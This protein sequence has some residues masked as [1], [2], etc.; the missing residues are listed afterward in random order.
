MN[1]YL[2]V[3]K[4]YADFNGRARRKEFWM[5]VLFNLI[6][7]IIAIWLDRLLGTE[8]DFVSSGYGTAYSFGWIYTLYIL[9]ILIPGLAVSV[10]RLHDTGKSGWMLLVALIPFVG[11][12]WLIVLYATPGNVGDNAYGPD[13]KA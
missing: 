2:Q 13:P 8:F 1:W 3:L 6:F 9:F 11:G 5:F 12:I 7:S 10:R 4:K